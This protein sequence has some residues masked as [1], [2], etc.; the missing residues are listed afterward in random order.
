MLQPAYNALIY[1]SSILI[2]K[3]QKLS[4][5]ITKRVTDP[6]ANADIQN[7]T[8]FNNLCINNAKRLNYAISVRKH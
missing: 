2:Q 6:F 4:D 8:V 3:D 7:P 5:A 1:G